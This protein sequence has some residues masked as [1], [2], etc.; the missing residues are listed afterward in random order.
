MLTPRSL[1]LAV[2]GNSPDNPPGSYSLQ[3]CLS[4]PY[5][6]G[7]LGQEKQLTVPNTQN[8]RRKLFLEFAASYAEPFRSVMEAITDDTEIKSVELADWPPPKDL[9]TTGKVVL[10]GD[11][12]HQM[13]MCKSPRSFYHFFPLYFPWPSQYVLTTMSQT[14]VRGQT[15]RLLMLLTLRTTLFHCL[16]PQM[17]LLL[18]SN[19]KGTSWP[20]FYAVH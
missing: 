9:H 3:I 6:D 2:P 1:V 5:R 16:G 11:S 14:A 8:E 20:N 13:A 10:M 4:W 15:T 17:R 7:Y 18:G 19:Q 12:L